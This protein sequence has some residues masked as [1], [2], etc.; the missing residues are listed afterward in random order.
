M[1]LILILSLMSF[2]SGLC[3]VF[4]FFIIKKNKNVAYLQNLL[5]HQNKTILHL[6]KNIKTY[7]IIEK[8]LKHIIHHDQLTG[9]PNH[10]LYH[11]L[12]TK[13]ISIAKKNHSQFFL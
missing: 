6:T 9:L 12:A 7:K 11:I 2:L 3:L 8:N 10:I 1:G 5:A 13:C 4:Y